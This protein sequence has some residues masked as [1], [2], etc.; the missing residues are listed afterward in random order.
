[1]INKQ[2]IEIADRAIKEAGIVKDDIYPLKT[3][4]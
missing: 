4:G 2:W 3:L 1:M